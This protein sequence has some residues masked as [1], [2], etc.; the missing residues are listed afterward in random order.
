MLPSRVSI[1][2]R[3]PWFLQMYNI[4]TSNT[5]SKGE[6]LNVITC[7]AGYERLTLWP[8]LRSDTEPVMIFYSRKDLTIMATFLALLPSLDVADKV[9]HAFKPSTRKAEAGISL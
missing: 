1:S 2:L 4:N 3:E 5:C 9:A 6:R 7:A 8:S